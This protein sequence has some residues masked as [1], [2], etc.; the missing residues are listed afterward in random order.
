MSFRT[1]F[2]GCKIKTKHIEYQI[3]R[4][5]TAAV[6]TG[7]KN[8]QKVRFREGNTVPTTVHPEWLKVMIFFEIY[9][10]RALCFSNEKKTFKN[11]LFQPLAIRCK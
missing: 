8:P 9:S 11:H 6:D 3:P 1:F 7:L 10:N 4:G 2:S 5:E